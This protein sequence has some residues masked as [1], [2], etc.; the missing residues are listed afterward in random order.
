MANYGYICGKNRCTSSF[1]DVAS[2]NEHRSRC[3]KKGGQASTGQSASPRAS[4]YN[5]A[6]A[7]VMKILRR[8]DGGEEVQAAQV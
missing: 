4:R 8:G 7:D 3:N 1:A 5:A 6:V 2:A